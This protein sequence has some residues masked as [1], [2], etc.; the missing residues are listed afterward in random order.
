MT[1]ERDIHTAMEMLLEALGESIQGLL[2]A[3]GEAFKAGRLDAAEELLERAKAVRGILEEY[4]A[5]GQRLYEALGEKGSPQPEP[6]T[7][8]TTHFG[9]YQR[10]VLQA[11]VDLGGR[12]ETS[13]ALDRVHQLMED[14][15]TPADHERVSSG[16]VR[17]KSTAAWV[18]FRLVKEGLLVADS[19]YGVWEI[20][21]EGR[22]WLEEQ[23]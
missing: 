1:E 13:D 6:S 14:V 5:L 10:P 9:Q 19:P 11:L 16:R 15:L 2:E 4:Q 18:R 12:A 8:P 20:T 22:R 17:W 23:G 7:G 21:E 3:G